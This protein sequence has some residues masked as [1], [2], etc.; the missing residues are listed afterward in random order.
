MQEMVSRRTGTYSTVA[1][2]NM[3]DI[4][5]GYYMP[6]PERKHKS[7]TRR[8][9]NHKNSTAAH[10]QRVATGLQRGEY[11]QIYSIA[12]GSTYV[13]EAQGGEL[14]YDIAE[15]NPTQFYNRVLN[16]DIKR[17]KV[18]DH[19]RL[20]F[21]WTQRPLLKIINSIKSK[22]IKRLSAELGGQFEKDIQ[23]ALNNPEIQENLKEM[24]ENNQV[25]L[26]NEDGAPFLQKHLEDLKKQV[27]NEEDSEQVDIRI[28]SP[29]MNKLEN[30]E[31]HV[32]EK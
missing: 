14:P 29:S 8:L 22:L 31:L 3:D 12:P 32:Q 9:I 16:Q 10:K 26:L 17:C 6:G 23:N 1:L 20:F 13:I 19:N 15:S 2:T 28:E 30:A 7:P 5:D 25:E 24:V 11:S 21:V 27:E 18:K 4:L